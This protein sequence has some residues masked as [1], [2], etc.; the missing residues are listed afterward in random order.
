MLVTG[1]SLGPYHPIENPCGTIPR[2][3]FPPA[4]FWSTRK[5]WTSTKKINMGGVPCTTVSHFMCTTALVVA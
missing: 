2:L 1:Q 5:I 4:G 3:N